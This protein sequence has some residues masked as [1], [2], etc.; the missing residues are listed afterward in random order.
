[1]LYLNEKGKRVSQSKLLAN[2][3]QGF[4]HPIEI[5]HSSASLMT[6]FI[7][8]RVYTT[9]FLNSEI[10]EPVQIE[11]VQIKLIHLNWTISNQSRYFRGLVRPGASTDQS[12]VPFS[13]NEWRNDLTVRSKKFW[14]NIQKR[15]NVRS[16]ENVKDSS[17]LEKKFFKILKYYFRFQKK[18]SHMTL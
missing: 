12:N 1:M 8:V 11:I 5:N 18:N 10:H 14:S 17:L 15:K 6:F 9:I 7:E 16:Y 2:Q 13:V 3:I 4:H